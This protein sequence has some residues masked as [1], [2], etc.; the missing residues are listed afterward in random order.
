MSFRFK[1]AALGGAV[2]CIFSSVFAATEDEAAVVV[3]TTRIPYREVE[4]T[5]AA[6]VHSHRMIERSGAQSLV[7]YLGQHSS[8]SVTPSYGNR[9]T[10][11]I[12]MRG[13]GSESGNQNV[14]ITI[15]GQRLN[16]IDL[17]PQLLG[18]IPL[19]NIDRIE[20]TKGSGSVMHGDG[21]MAG[22]INI[23]TRPHSG[24]SV[25]AR[26]GNHGVVAGSL[27][28]GISREQFSISVSADHE[29]H[30]GFAED[31]SSGKRDMSLLRSE[32]AQLRFMPLSALTL[33]L[34]MTS[35]HA[36]TRYQNPLT[37]TQYKDDPRQNGGAAIYT[38]YVT[39]AERWRVG[40]D[41]AFSDQ[42]KLTYDHHRLDQEN[43]SAAGW[44]SF[45]AGYDTSGDDLALIFNGEH[46][47][48]SAGLQRADARRAQAANDTDKV[49]Q[50]YYLQAAY[51]WNAT[52]LSLGTRHEQVRYR[53]SPVAGASLSDE[54]SLNAWDLGVNHRLS[55]EITLF[56]NLNKSFQAP[57]VDR[58]F[59]FFGTFNGFIVPAEAKTFNTGLHR[60]VGSGNKFK[61]SFFRANLTNE[62]YYDPFTFN[63]T[64]IDQSH[65]YGLELQQYW[66]AT[67]DLA[68]NAQY[69]WTR[70]KIDR[71]DSATGAYDGK[72]MPGVPRHALNL[73]ATYAFDNRTDATLSHAWRGRAYAISDF[74]N[75]NLQRQEATQTTNLSLRHRH[76]SMEVFA[77][78]S[79]LFN[80]KNGV[81]AGDNTIYPV[82]YSRSVVVGVKTRF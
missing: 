9:M 74:D 24:V 63:N 3:S 15:D 25:E 27:A 76:E 32:R 1:Q 8:L 26:A 53:Y 59:T 47:D 12:E 62:I 29:R 44:G 34:D 66:K 19:S 40:M 64:N 55:N 30:G 6:E 22:V 28:A 16:T 41:Y 2:Y 72:E 54:I 57:D 82:N 38:N 68:L 56:A 4:A 42:L 52:T 7:D 71:E 10:P 23:F 39:D 79:N 43:V 17:Q 35:A 77:T 60:V 73:S 46:V 80:R 70:A 69:T 37:R 13:Y 11:T 51:R 48:L 75:N 18:A 81:W 50:A 14:V 49:N 20:I 21:A 78:V 36:D 67:A 45:S 58:F 61:L 31:D 33:K 65:K 5:Y